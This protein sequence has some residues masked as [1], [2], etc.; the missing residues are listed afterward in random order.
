MGAMG[1]VLHISLDQ[2]REFSS[3]EQDVLSW[4]RLGCSQTTGRF[5]C[6]GGSAWTMS[7]MTGRRFAKASRGRLDSVASTSRHWQSS[8]KHM[9]LAVALGS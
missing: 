4:G 5:E 7:P 9:R 3:A 8:A 6:S 1:Q 2:A